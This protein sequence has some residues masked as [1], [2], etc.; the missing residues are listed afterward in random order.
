MSGAND[1]T[2]SAPPPSNSEPSLWSRIRSRSEWP[3]WIAGWVLVSL[4]LIELLIALVLDASLG[5]AMVAGMVA[6]VLSGR[7]GGIPVAIAAGVPPVLVWQVSV[8]QDI[9]FFCLL[10]P[11]FLV[12][13]HERQGK[14]GFIMRRLERFEEEARKRQGFARKWGPVGVFLFMLTPFIVNGPMVGGILGRLV[15][16]RTRHLLAPVILSTMT[17]SA[18]W[19]IFFVKTIDRLEAID[20]RLGYGLAAVMFFGFIAAAGVGWALEKRNGSRSSIEH[21]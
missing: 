15:G 16:I 7:E 14:G 17:A 13:Y 2:A 10:F 20:P 5:R 19:T 21:K 4:L 18:F 8:T 6:E 12:T 3:L 1:G 11:V 9:A